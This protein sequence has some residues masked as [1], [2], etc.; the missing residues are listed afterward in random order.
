MSFIAM[1]HVLERNDMQYHSQIARRSRIRLYVIAFQGAAFCFFGARIASAAEGPTVDVVIK[2]V[3]RI[4]TVTSA[5][6]QVAGFKPHIKFPWMEQRGDGSL[7]TWWTVGQTHGV[8]D[9][10]LAGGSS[11]SFDDGDTW[12]TPTQVYTITPPVTQMRPSGQTSRGYEVNWTSSTPR[13]SWGGLRY[14]SSDGGYNWSTSTA[15]YN[16]NGVGYVNLFQQQGPIVA[17]NSEIFFTAYGQRNTSDTTFETVLFASTDNGANWTR[18]STISAYVPGLNLA[19]GAEGPSETALIKLDNGNLLSVFRTGQP[20]PSNN[21]NAA[22]P[23]IY[24]T[25]SS[26]GGYT[27]TTPKMLGVTG[28]S[29]HLNKLPDGTVAM[30][31]GRYGVNML[32][33]DPTASRWSFPTVIMDESTDGHARMYERSDGDWVMAYDRTSFY[34]PSDN[35]NPPAGYVYANDQEAHM[36]IATL[37]ITPQT[38]TEDYSWAFEYHGDVTPDALAVPWSIAQGGTTSVRLWGDLGQDYIRTDSGTTG[39]NRSVS[40]VL[41]GNTPSS[42]WA[43]VDFA[44]GFVL[45]IRARAGSTSTAASSATV[46]LSDG[47]NGAIMLELTSNYVGLEGLGGNGAQ[48]NHAPVG[49]SPRS[50]HEYRIVVDTDDVSG[51]VTAKLYID[52]DWDN[53]ILT[54]LLAATADDEVRFGDITGTNNGILDLDYLRFAHSPSSLAF[55]GDFNGDGLVDGA[56]YSVWR[57]HYGGEDESA[58]HGG[59]DG[60]NGVDPA[61]FELWKSNFGT[62]SPDNSLAAVPE[63]STLA[64]CVIGCLYIVAAAR[65][66]P[67]EV[68]SNS[69]NNNPA[70]RMGK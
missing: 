5:D 51:L 23:S 54:Q 47:T 53:A 14:S 4:Y 32:F 6:S 57:D 34:H 15:F 69:I 35:N 1:S 13:T 16:S 42:A 61:D 22:T 43:D 56:D 62:S 45:D 21:I 64:L 12:T 26:D 48:V 40:Y 39:V 65:R 59:G 58:L 10:A 20:Y 46:Y 63:A 3:N 7:F 19:M 41:S 49:F 70:G 25:I 17:R 9:P 44:D 33:A 2:D 52:G 38:V 27:W 18:R 66:S 31:Y 8:Q 36:E 50:W 55:S 67:A 30:T 24:S 29:P 37:G 68:N 11:Q 60:L 28:V